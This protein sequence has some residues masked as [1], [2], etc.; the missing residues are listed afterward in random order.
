MSENLNLYYQR[1][2]DLCHQTLIQNVKMRLSLVGL[3]SRTIPS[4]L[5]NSVISLQTLFK[6]L[7]R[8]SMCIYIY[9]QILFTILSQINSL[10]NDHALI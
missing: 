10:H 4:K 5:K 2:Q 1:N 8:T 9:T 7:L 6:H 3:P